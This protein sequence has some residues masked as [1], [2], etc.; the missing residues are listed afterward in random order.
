MEEEEGRMLNQG[1][2]RQWECFTNKH[3]KVAGN[4]T[5]D[6]TTKGSA[7]PSPPALGATRVEVDT[8]GT[9]VRLGILY[10]LTAVINSFTFGSGLKIMQSTVG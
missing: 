5:R 1:E 7:R 4:S 3:F 6:T 9:S 2:E 8:Y 10:V